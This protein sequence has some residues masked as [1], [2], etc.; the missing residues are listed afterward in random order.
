M[1]KKK[2]Q[3]RRKQGSRRTREVFDSLNKK[4]K[5]NSPASWSKQREKYQQVMSVSRY[6][7]TGHQQKFFNILADAHQK[8]V[9]TRLKNYNK[10][11]KQKQQDLSEGKFSPNLRSQYRKKFNYQ[12]RKMGGNANEG[13]YKTK[14]LNPGVATPK[15]MSRFVGEKGER[16]PVVEGKYIAVPKK[17]L[18]KLKQ[19]QQENKQ[20]LDK[21]LSKYPESQKRLNKGRALYN[22]RVSST[23]IN[24]FRDDNAFLYQLNNEYD[25]EKKNEDIERYRDVYIR[26]IDE[27]MNLTDEEKDMLI[28]KLNSLTTEEFEDFYFSDSH[29]DLDLWY[30]SDQATA[31]EQISGESLTQLINSILDYTP[32]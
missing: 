32:E 20:R 28:D 15:Y 10:Q 7:L 21:K 3:Y 29:Y 5:R 18:D 1:A 14:M 2:K 17:E 26:A 27:N 4:Q 22:V 24:S 19:N 31:N 8:K 9:D 13:V 11:Q 30:D 25:E 16:V 23:D 12:N 6:G